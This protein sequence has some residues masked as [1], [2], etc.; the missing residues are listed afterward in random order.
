MN[1][2]FRD[3]ETYESVTLR[4]SRESPS[5]SRCSEFNGNLT[6]TMAEN[7]VCESARNGND[8]SFPL[9]TEEMKEDVKR[10]LSAGH[11]S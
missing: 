2:T 4:G 11:R 10:C 3:A 8:I 7:G 5:F 9:R 1:V 6:K